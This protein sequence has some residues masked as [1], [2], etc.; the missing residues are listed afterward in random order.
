MIFKVGDK[1]IASDFDKELYG[2]EFV[3]ITDV[4]KKYKLYHWEADWKDGI[5]YSG[6]SFKDAKKYLEEDYSPYC[7]VCSGCGEEGC[8]SATLC[9]QSPDGLYCKWYLRDLKFGY[10]MYN[11]IMDLISNDEET[12]KK[13]NE[14]WEKNYNIFYKTTNNQ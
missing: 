7:P 8:C 13:F 9:E 3:T 12:Q 5:I 14:I 10:R 4:N 6:Y 1:L 2:L 11:D